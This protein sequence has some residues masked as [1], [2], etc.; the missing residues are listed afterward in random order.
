MP[1]RDFR[2][3]QWVKFT[4]DVAGAHRSSDGKVVGIYNRAGRDPLTGDQ[5]P[6]RVFP[7]AHE[8]GGN[9]MKLVDDQAVIVR[10]DPETLP[11]I[12]AVTDVHDI[13]PERLRGT[14]PGWKP[15]P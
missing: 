11:D 10:L 14:P 7:V 5:L 8:T 4:A 13:P 15:Q 12:E 1:I 3:G 6:N 2:S 9:I